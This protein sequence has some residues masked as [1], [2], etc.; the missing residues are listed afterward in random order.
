VRR[1]ASAAP[2]LRQKFLIAADAMAIN[3][4][5]YLVPNQ[6]QLGTPRLLW[7]TRVDEMTAFRG[8]E[9]AGWAAESSA[10]EAGPG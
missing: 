1:P 2:H 6:V 10:A 3:A 5:L 4:V 7:W 8:R 9:R